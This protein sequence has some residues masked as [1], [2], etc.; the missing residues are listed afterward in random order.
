MLLPGEARLIPL[1]FSP[2]CY[3]QRRQLSRPVLSLSLRDDTVFVPSHPVAS[4]PS[5]P[6]HPETTPD[7]PVA[8]A[9][10]LLP[11]RRILGYSR[12]PAPPLSIELPAIRPPPNSEVLEATNI[13]QAPGLRNDYYSNL[14]SWLATTGKITV[15]LGPDVYI[16]GGS[17]SAVHQLLLPNTSPITCVES[18]IFY[19]IVAS[20]LG[21]V[22]LVDNTHTTIDTFANLLG[23]VFV[24]RW[25][26]HG[27]LFYLGDEQGVVHYYEVHARRMTRVAT[28]S[29]HQQQICGMSIFFCTH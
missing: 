16:W 20:S 9:L 17:D 29:S 26:P 10:H 5:P 22:F 28:L 21:S 3:K 4:S 12:T 19:T 24:C 18:G 13:L 25:F 23:C 1:S 11:R 27:R 8:R 7:D 6:A 2:Y 14:I 15:G